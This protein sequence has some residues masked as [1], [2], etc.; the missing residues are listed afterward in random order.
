LG[1]PFEVKLEEIANTEKRMVQKN[2][3]RATTEKERNYVGLILQGEDLSRVIDW[4][5]EPMIPL[6]SEQMFRKPI[7]EPSEL[8][9]LHS[10]TIDTLSDERRGSSPFGHT[11][12]MEVYLNSSVSN[13]IFHEGREHNGNEGKKPRDFFRMLIMN[14][15][16]QTTWHKNELNMLMRRN[17]S[18]KHIPM[19]I[20]ICLWP[21]Q[22]KIYAVTDA[23]IVLLSSRKDLATRTCQQ[24]MDSI[25]RRWRMGK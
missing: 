24:F 12:R 2:L 4:Q 5:A 10:E 23:H 8:R 18:L 17:T 15:E 16:D 19:V 9:R 7:S 25:L 11:T 22:E 1:K 20:Q 3:A 13:H 21:F 14:A 6:P